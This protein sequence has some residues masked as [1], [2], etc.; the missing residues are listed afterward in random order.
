MIGQREFQV[1]RLDPAGRHSH[2]TM[3]RCSRFFFALLF[4]LAAGSILRASAAGLATDQTE[5]EPGGTALILGTDFLP[6]EIVVLQI[7]HADGSAAHQPWSAQANAQGSV[8]SQ[9]EVCAEDCVGT[10]LVLSAVGQSSGAVA[11]TV[12]S[13]GQV[14][15]KTRLKASQSSTQLQGWFNLSLIWGGT[16]Q[17]SN[18]RYSEG[19]SIPLRINATLTPGTTHTVLLQYDFS[20]GGTARFFDALT[21]YTNGVSNVNVL[22]GITGAGA[23]TVWGIPPDTSLPNGA[24]PPGVVTT[25]NVTGLTFGKYAITNGVKSLPVT[26]TV[27]GSGKSGVPVVIAYGGHLASASVWGPN[28]GASQFPGASTKAYLS[29][30]G[31]PNHNLSVNPA[32]VISSADLSLTVLA[33]PQPVF[34]TSNLVYTLI[35]SNLGPDTASSVVVTD[36]LPAGVSFISATTSQGASTGVNPPSFNL[37]SLNSSN[38]ATITVVTRVTASI[39]SWITNVALV[40]STTLDPVATNNTATV[41]STVVDR[42]PPVLTCPSDIIVTTSPGI[43]GS[44]VTFSATATDD[45]QVTINYS[46]NPGSFFPVGTNTVICTATDA[47]GNSATCAF[48]VIVRDTEPPTIACPADFAVNAD[49]GLCSAVVTFNVTAMD[50]CGAA[51]VNCTPPSGSSFPKGTNLVTCLATDA[52]GNTNICTFH[53]VVRDNQPPAL[54]CPNNLIVQATPNRCDAIVTYSVVSALDNCDGPV[55]VVCTPAS[56][57]LFPIGTNTVVCTATDSSGNATNCS[58]LV[59]VL[60]APNVAWPL[61]QELA[62]APNG[63]VQQGSIQQC[64]T[65]PDQAHWYKFKGQPGSRIIVTLTSLPENYDLVLF[66]DIG[67]AYKKLLLSGDLAHISAEFAGDAFSPSA[68]SPSAFS[69]SAFSP[70]AFS[71]SAFSPSAF[72]PSAFSPSAFSPSAFSPSA[73]SPDAYAP[74]AFSPSAFSPSAFSPSAFSPSAFSPSAF[75]PS[76]FSAAQ[77]QSI[78]GVSAFDGT[79]GE[80]ILADTW[81]NDGYFYI[82]VRG[83]NGVFSPGNPFNLSVFLQPGACGSV[84]PVALDSTGNPLPAD[85]TSAP[86]GPYK[87]IILTD[88]NRWLGAGPSPA[89]TNLSLKLAA[90]AARSEVAG[91]IVDVGADPTIAFLNAQADANFDCPYAKNLVARALQAIV[92]RSRSGIPGLQYVVLIGDD[93]VIPYFRYPDL[94][95]LGPEQNYVPPVKDL[96]AS[97]ASLQLNYVLSQD[98]YGAQCDFSLKISD[99]PLADLAVGRLVQT[100]DEVSGMIDAYLSTSA[101]V[102]P[103]PSSAL[104]T[105]YDFLADDAQAVTSELALGMGVTPDTLICPNTTAPSLCW[106]AD[107]LRQALFSKRHDIVFLAGHFSASETLAADFMTHMFA[108][109]LAGSPIDFGNSLIFSAGCHSGYNMA[110]PDFI[111]GVSI[112]PDWTRACAQKKATL[113]AGTGY[114]YGDTDFIEYSERLYLEFAQQLRS[115]SGPVPVGQALLQ[116]KHAFLAE[117]P[118]VRGIHAKSYLEATLFGL[119][120]ISVQMPAA[121]R[122]VGGAVPVV[123]TVTP[124]TTDPGKTLGL[125]YADVVVMPNLVPH[126]VTLS[127]TVDSTLTTATYLSGNDGVVNNPAEPV[128]PLEVRNATV[129]TTVLRGVGFRAGTFSDVLGNVPFTGAPTETIRG[130]HAAFLSEV[131]YPMQPWGVNYFGGL[132]GGLDGLTRLISIPAQFKSDSSTAITGT[133]R[134]F[135]EMDFR[136][137]YNSNLTTYVSNGVVSIPGLSAPPSISGILGTTSGGSVTLSAHVV[138]NPSAG[139]QGV[140]V[141][142]TAS[143]GTYAGKWQSLDLTQ[144]PVDSTLWTGVLPLNGTA[145]QDIRYMVQAVNGIGEVALDTKF[146]A[147]HVPDEFDSGS[148][149]GLAPTVLTLLPGPTS[150]QY[151][152]TPTFSA[153][154]S[155]ANGAPLAGQRIVFSL[156]GQQI[157]AITDSNGKATAGMPLRSTPGTYQLNALFRGAP[158]LGPSS[159]TG[160]FTITRQ[161]TALSISPNLI[162]SKTNVD[163]KITAH[164]T[165]GAGN[166]ILERTVLFV[167]TGPNGSYA[168]PITT[169]IN[170]NAPLGKVNL[171][172]G[173]YTV[174]AFFN[175]TIPLPGQS[176]TVDDGIH[177]PSSATGPSLIVDDAP[178]LILCSPNIIVPADLGTCTATVFYKTNVTDNNPGVTVVCA[179]P[180]GTLFQKGTNIVSWTATD[181]AG[182]SSSCSFLVIVLDTQ[183]PAVTCSTNIVVSTDVGKPTAVVNFTVSAIDNCDSS[184]IVTSVPAS[185]T[186][187]PIGTNTVVATAVDSSGNS[188]QCSFTV[189]VRDT[190]P[191]VVTSVTASP[192]VLWPPN[193]E[194]ILVTITVVASDN[195]GFVTSKIIS[196]T[197]SDPTNT[198]GDGNTGGDW[199]VLGPLTLDLRA[200]R[201]SQSVGRT[202]TI[203][204]QTTDSFGNITYSTV[205]ATVPPNQ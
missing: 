64:L 177:V 41:V 89:K 77:I 38:T 174:S 63:A 23:S 99:L 195:S 145:S 10:E 80:G 129:P 83:R 117:T 3:N 32:A 50:N 21:S 74:S 65:A 81:D 121:R 139:I 76:A 78:V 86:S 88:L 170:G 33:T 151:G 178:P 79:A 182:N 69:P 155:A 179:P 66:K 146:G 186:A 70:S 136:L 93:S 30:D 18:S 167:V 49:H 171:P 172:D 68:F 72:S 176:I 42:N 144:S 82:R 119:P 137:F 162:Y 199:V 188:N 164:L 108:F 157:W 205:T 71:P 55:T 133:L 114:Q 181:L 98:A 43:C 130:V 104:V 194:M 158:S 75:S 22:A 16:I 14:Q 103:T 163:T 60:D 180:S 198:T 116:A 111:P 90:L 58:F 193:H 39:D 31:G 100:P 125:G 59:V 56:G 160:L 84:S 67:A 34:S 185:G 128:L 26:F 122:A 132:C 9:W 45:D 106:T 152:S 44:N 190:A 138:G 196:V 120:M 169:D 202:Y 27:A 203:T 102:M 135:S 141:T 1:R 73:F 35:V 5:Y 57:S 201:A 11:N 48:H 142:Y 62:L 87:T 24:Q 140:W 15:S 54:V 173:S 95:L 17:G 115:G 150:G 53:V 28:N 147:Y 7:Q 156:S 113:V 110:G 13:D 112:E 85:T 12:F 96:T 134:E 6:G 184:P 97:Q 94:A 192:A 47:D 124:I 148:T 204:I 168:V 118:E 52:S 123:S 92:N 4:F 46:I 36:T 109:E 51:S 154:L 197:S 200:E 61:A 107:N 183:P 8:V 37:G 159:T 19:T 149:S 187:F 29:F 20:T 25:Y 101:G 165:D 161:T 175:G 189:T 191:P 153:Q 166:P 127:N 126:Q 131:F 40:A 2:Q 91:V 105:G 143:N